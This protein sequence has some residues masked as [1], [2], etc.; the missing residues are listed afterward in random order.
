MGKFYFMQ[1]CD[2]F[3]VT[4]MNVANKVC[5]HILL[6]NECGN[7]ESEYGNVDAERDA[8]FIDHFVVTLHGAQRGFNDCTA[9]VLVLFAG[10]DKW[11]DANHSFAPT[12]VSLPLPLVISQ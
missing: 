8:I 3:I 4:T 10:R 2:Q 12:S 9:G 11:L 6:M 7:G 5:R 1:Q